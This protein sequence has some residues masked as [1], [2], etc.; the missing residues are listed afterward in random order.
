MTILARSR[1]RWVAAVL[2]VAAALLA[3]PATAAT[4]IVDSVLDLPDDLTIPG[5]CHTSANNCTLRAAVMQANRAGVGTIVLPAGIYRLTIPR[6]GDGGEENGDLDLTTPAVGSPLVNV[7]GA[8]A[9][10]TVI[11]AGQID[12]VLRVHAGRVAAISGVTLRNGA[13]AVNDGG[14]GILN[15]GLLNLDSVEV[16]GNNSTNKYGGGSSTPAL[17]R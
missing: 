11:D 3:P 2:L 9:A 15:E 17:S 16:S 13:T 1:P 5:V 12:R 7:L 10:T 14:G 8:G 4:F 6:S